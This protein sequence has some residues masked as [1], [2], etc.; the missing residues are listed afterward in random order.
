MS[1]YRRFSPHPKSIYPTITTYG[2]QTGVPQRQRYGRASLDRP[3]ARETTDTPN[4]SS[5]AAYP[6]VTFV[7]IINPHNGPGA[8]SQPDVA[9]SREIGQLNSLPNVRLVGYVR[10]NYCERDLAEVHEDVN[11]Y[12]GWSALTSSHSA[13]TSLAVHG[14][15]FDETPNLYTEERANYL[16]DVTS[17]V[18]NSSG[19]L[20]DRVVSR[21]S[22]FSC[23]F[24]VV[25]LK[26][27][28][29]DT[30]RCSLSLDS[31][32][33]NSQHRRFIILEPFL[34]LSSQIQGLT[35]RR[36]WRRAGQN[37]S[38]EPFRN[39]CRCCYAMTEIDAA[40]WYIR[41]P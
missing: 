18:K 33:T 10:I 37:T 24:F 12:A 23:F 35:L 41:C 13:E 5:I 28:Y 11:K 1:R 25:L 21:S 7:V 40:L 31:L 8:S 16:D 2:Q 36:S 6:K 15:F 26:L 17:L 14:I 29:D 34:P 32:M 9:Y 27:S 38:R 39:A 3:Q 19:I 4:N 20:G 22:A 30:I